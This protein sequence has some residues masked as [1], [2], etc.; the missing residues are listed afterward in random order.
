MATIIENLKSKISQGAVVG[1]PFNLRGVAP[2]FN[3]DRID[4]LVELGAVTKD[5]NIYD[6]GHLVYCAENENIYIFRGHTGGTNYIGQFELFGSGSGSGNGALFEYK[7]NIIWEKVRKDGAPDGRGVGFYF[8][9]V[10]EMLLFGVKGS[11]NRTLSPARSQVNLIRTQKRV[12]IR[13]II[14]YAI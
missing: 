3:R 13:A 1:S 2:N 9:N 5:D 12:W 7:G 11:N 4:S 10:T 6:I 14:P 8:R